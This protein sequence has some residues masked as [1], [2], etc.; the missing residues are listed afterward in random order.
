MQRKYTIP[1]FLVAVTLLWSATS[2]KKFENGIEVPSYIHI[3]SITVSCDYYTYGAST[4]HITDAWVYID[5]QIIGCYELPATFPVL[6]K[7][8][9]KVTIYGGIMVDGRSAAR[10][11]YSFYAPMVYRDLNLVQ[12]SIVKLNPVLNYYDLGLGTNVGWKEDFEQGSTLVKTAESDTSLF[13]VGYPEAWH[14]DPLHSSFSGRVI[15]PPDSLHFTLANSDPLTNLPTNSNPV[16][17]EMD[18]NCNAAFTVGLIY[19][20]DYKVTEWPLVTVT[21]TDSI[22]AMPGLWKKI[23]I[24]FGPTLVENRNAEYFKVYVTSHVYKGT[25]AE[26]VPDRTRYYYF[27]NMKLFYK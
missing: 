21:P 19:Y 3:D 10:A 12:D 7:G 11:P 18:Y 25:S 23:Y 15:L 4:S 22:N 6:K 14:A 17:L 8:P 26:Y 5:D 16:L 9:H 2:C 27:D 13:R 20:K 24:N 1:F